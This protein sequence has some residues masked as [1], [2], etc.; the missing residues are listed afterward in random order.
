MSTNIPASGN[1]RLIS[2]HHIGRSSGSV[3]QVA[4][5]RPLWYSLGVSRRVN[6]AALVKQVVQI[7]GD[8][9]KG[10]D[11]NDAK[12]QPKTRFERRHSPTLSTQQKTTAAMSFR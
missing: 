6:C 8:E 9:S 12:D 7:I 3:R 10:A 11:R 1:G 4:I 5:H 2:S